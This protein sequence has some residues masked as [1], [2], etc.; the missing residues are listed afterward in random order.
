MSLLLGLEIDLRKA[1]KQAE[2]PLIA[3]CFDLTKE[4]D[5][6]GK[7]SKNNHSAPFI[8]HLRKKCQENF[9]EREG[10]FASSMAKT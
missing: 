7:W 2:R 4:I 9:G 10:G 8:V 1:N 6:K 3:S 5:R